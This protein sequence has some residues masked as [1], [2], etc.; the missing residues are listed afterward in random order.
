MKKRLDVLVFEKGLVKSREEAQRLILAKK[1][2]TDGEYI[3]K[4]GT[5]V[6]EDSKI[7]VEKG[8]EFVGKGA[9]K[10]QSTFQR[11]KLNFKNKTV[12]DIGASTG[13]FTDFA[14]KKG[15]KRVYAVDVGYGQLAFP[16]RGN[17][18]V[19]NMER[20][21]IRD[22]ESFPER[23]DIFLIDVSFISLRRILP[24]IKELID[25][26]A[27][28]RSAKG[29]TLG[30]QKAEIL[31]LVKP[32]FEVGKKIADRFKGV[33]KDVKIQKQVTRDIKNFAEKEGFA[34]ISS[35]KA[36]VKGEKG[37]QEYFLYLRYPKNVLTFGAFDLLHEGHKFFLKEAQKHG[38]LKVVV[39]SD[40]KIF[41]LKKRKPVHKIEERIKNLKKM[42]VDA[43]IEEGNPWQNVLKNKADII[44][45]GYDQD[46]EEEIKKK[47]KKT[48]YLVKIVKI[49]KALN[50]KIFKTA[51]F[52]KNLTK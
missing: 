42:G 3:T 41:E 44:V 33:I 36:G 51:L 20:T 50:P 49:K 9:K 4:A 16:L 24:K 6:E 30:G 13:G 39:P 34:A 22:V 18:K 48:S 1:V 29:Q 26:S 21:D 23:I 31:P 14:L 43:E 2:K 8:E 19:I 7:E 35:V 40:E 10:I 38:E 12:A 32:Q 47:M 45:L 25:K 17:K 46:W 15:A 27:K 5:K 11:F 52:R 28:R 37:N